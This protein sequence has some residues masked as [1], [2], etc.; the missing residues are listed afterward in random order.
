M[1]YFWTKVADIKPKNGDIVET[2]IDDERGVRNQGDLKWWKG[3]W[4]TPDGQMYVYYRP[5]HWRP[6]P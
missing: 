5:T 3:M 1:K 6:I 4:W 2:K